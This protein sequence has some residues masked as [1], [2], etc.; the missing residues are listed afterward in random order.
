MNHIFHAAAVCV[1]YYST[2]RHPAHA[3]SVPIRH[4]RDK[5]FADTIFE[6]DI[7]IAS[8]TTRY[9]AH[10]RYTHTCDVRVVLLELGGGALGIFAFSSRQFAPTIN[11][12]P[13]SASHNMFYFSFLRA[14]PSR[15]E[16]ESRKSKWCLVQTCSPSFFK[17]RK[18]ARSTTDCQNQK[19]ER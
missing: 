12:G 7:Y 9:Q 5:S 14:R 3:V 15:I 19:V 11:H 17:F 2:H 8:T 1:F 13:L 4:P 6:T 18:N 10:T 16:I